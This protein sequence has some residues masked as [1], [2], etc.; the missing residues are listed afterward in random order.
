MDKVVVVV[1][2]YQ[3]CARP[4][5]SS[6]MPEISS[7]CL[8]SGLVVHALMSM[9]THARTHAMPLFAYGKYGEDDQELP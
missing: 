8:R 6:S 5:I 2:S 1:E 7:L 9:L 4:R 3:R